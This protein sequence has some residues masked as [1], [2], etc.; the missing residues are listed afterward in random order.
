MAALFYKALVGAL[1]VV[2][3]AL[4]SKTKSFYIAGQEETYTD[5]DQQ[6]NDITKLAKVDNQWIVD[7]QG[8]YYFPW[9]GK[10]NVGI[11]N[12]LDEEPPM[13]DYLGFPYYDTKLY[14]PIGRE[15]YLRYNQKF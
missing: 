4:L 7:V 6:G 2:C 9:N 12:L 1:A 14:D 8:G 3:I 11:R 10:L 5:K 13:E 15:Y